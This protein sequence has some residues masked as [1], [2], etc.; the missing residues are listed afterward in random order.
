MLTLKNTFDFRGSVKVVKLLLRKD[1]IAVANIDGDF[2]VH[3][4][5]AAGNLPVVK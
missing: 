3:V 5:A 1:I 4:A 2:P